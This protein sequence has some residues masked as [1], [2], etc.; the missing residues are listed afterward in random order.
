MGPACSRRVP[1]GHKALI[2]GPTFGDAITTCWQHPAG[3]SAHN[4]EVRLVNRK[5]ATVVVWPNGAEAQF[6]GLHTEHD[7]ELLRARA[8]NCCCF[9]IDEAALA[10]HLR[11]AVDL[12]QQRARLGDKPHGIVT[13]TPRPS[14]GWKYL[15]GLPEV[16]VTRGSSYDNAFLSETHKRR[17]GRFV[18]TRLERQEIYGELVDDYEGALWKRELIDRHRI[19]GSAGSPQERIA[20]LG[21]VRVAVG[22]D[23]STWIPELVPTGDEAGVGQGIETGIVVVGIDAQNPPH[24][25]VLEDLSGRYEA[26]EWARRACDAYHAWGA[27]FVVPETNAGGDMVLATI[28]LTDPNVTVYRAPG[29]NRPGVRASVGKR[30]RAEPVAMLSDQ[31]RWHHVGEFPALE[32]AMCGWDPTEPWSPDRIDAAVWSAVALNPAVAPGADVVA[33]QVARTRI[34]GFGGLGGPRG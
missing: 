34:P 2:A 15:V 13:S 27:A 3:L 12:I 19:T 5:E 14:P 30:A 28:R 11:L 10:R 22:I 26:I 33:A 8:A 25:Y 21:I 7:A 17:L 20:A 6:V 9:W 24:E 31:G 32:A 18:G 23:P 4:P 16:V 1:G 29:A